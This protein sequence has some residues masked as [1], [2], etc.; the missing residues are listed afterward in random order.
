MNQHLPGFEP[1]TSALQ[2]PR[3]DHYAKGACVM[4]PATEPSRC[5]VLR[6]DPSVK[7]KGG[8]QWC[9]VQAFRSAGHGI[10]AW[11]KK[12]EVYPLFKNGEIQE[13]GTEHRSCP[14]VGK[15]APHGCLFCVPGCRLGPTSGCWVQSRCPCCCTASSCT[16]PGRLCSS[17]WS[18]STARSGWRSSASPSLSFSWTRS[19]KWRPGAMSLLTTWRAES[20]QSNYTMAGRLF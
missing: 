13:E 5:L 2:V 8:T 12:R 19:S 10:C 15:S 14:E 16:C 4:C 3:N 11:P 6:C 1:G 18:P 20:R 9:Q 17:V 7:S